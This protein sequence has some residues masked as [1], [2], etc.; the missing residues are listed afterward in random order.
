MPYDEG[1]RR[2][3]RKSESAGFVRLA[4]KSI[5]RKKISL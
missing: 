1:F 5:T 4:K 3:R 2:R